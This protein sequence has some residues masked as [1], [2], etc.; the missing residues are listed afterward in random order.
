MMHDIRSVV[1]FGMPILFAGLLGA[2]GASKSAGNGSGNRG[3]QGNQGKGNPTA[4]NRGGVMW[5][6]FSGKTTGGP[7]R[8]YILLG[9]RM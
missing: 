7:S 9:I 3:N 6:L 8:R 1:M 5:I 2:C 4:G